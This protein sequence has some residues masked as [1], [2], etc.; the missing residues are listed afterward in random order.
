MAIKA[1]FVFQG[2]GAKLGCLVA[3]ADAIAANVESLGI[4]I[5]GVSGASA[6][7]VAAVILASG[8]PPNHFADRLRQIGPN[9]ISKVVKQYNDVIMLVYVLLGHRLYDRPKFVEFFNALLEL[10]DQPIK[11]FSDLKYPV[12]LFAT[13][14][15]T[16]SS[17]SYDNSSEILVAEALA[18]SCAIPFFLH[19]FRDT[20]DIIDGGLVSNLPIEHLAKKPGHS[21]DEIIAISF[22]EGGVNQKSS[23]L[24][25]YIMAIAATAIDSHVNKAITKLPTNHIHKIFTNTRTF[26]FSSALQHDLSP[27][28]YE[29]YKASVEKFLHDLAREKRLEYAT[30]SY[31]GFVQR[32]DEHHKHI[33][34]YQN[35]SVVRALYKWTSN[36]LRMQDRKQTDFCDAELTIR[37][38]KDFAS[39][40]G[41]R[42][43]SGDRLIH[44]GDVNVRVTDESGQAIACT[45]FPLPPEQVDSSVVSSNL[46]VFFQQPLRCGTY[47]IRYQTLAQQILY[48][49]VTEKG[50]DQIGYRAAY[51]DHV[52]ELLMLVNIP[53][54]LPVVLAKCPESHQPSDRPVWIDGEELSEA[55]IAHLAQP[56]VE[57]KAVGWRAR[58]LYKGYATGFLASLDVAKDFRGG[59]GI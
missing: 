4:E 34:A 41:V 40:I 49:V 1:Q 13:D 31:Q 58:N 47:R 37:V 14:L 16:K 21:Q 17:I 54:Q 23:S 3:A 30:L 20:K 18:D 56:A 28:P 38:E 35:I 46:L 25:E 44:I 15:A 32:L 55:E 27:T 45:V 7:A 39:V 50:W 53:R 2:G 59:E 11:K 19:T 26:D 43:S 10:D 29:G 12:H 36:S 6:G 22:S 33:V 57:Y 52:E 42:Y 24:K 9:F 8:R 5:R 51:M 48:D